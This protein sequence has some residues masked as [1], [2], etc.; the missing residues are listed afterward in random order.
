MRE[1]KIIIDVS[2]FLDSEH[3]EELED[4]IAEILQN[5]GVK[6]KIQSMATGNEITVT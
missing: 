4:K 2:T 1:P 3:Y 5:F 6:A